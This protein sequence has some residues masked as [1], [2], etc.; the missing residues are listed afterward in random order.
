MLAQGECLYQGATHNL[1]P[2]LESVKLPCPMYHNPA[3]Y[4]ENIFM[5]TILYT[6]AALEKP[7]RAICNKNTF[8][9]LFTE[10]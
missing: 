1:V 8:H 4:G 6:R 5:S 9:L 10:T 2:Y 7:Q 3:D